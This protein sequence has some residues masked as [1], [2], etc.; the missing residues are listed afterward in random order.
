MANQIGSLQ[1]KKKSSTSDAPLL[2]IVI[3]IFFIFAILWCSWSGDGQ[4]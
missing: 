3:F 4:W 2:R 1:K